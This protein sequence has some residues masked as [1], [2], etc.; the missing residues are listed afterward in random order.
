[1]ETTRRRV[2]WIEFRWKPPGGQRDAPC[3]TVSSNPPEGAMQV[4]RRCSPFGGGQAERQV[5]HQRQDARALCRAG[6]QKVPDGNQ[7]SN[8]LQLKDVPLLYHT[9]RV[10][11]MPV[12]ASQGRPDLCEGRRIEPECNGIARYALRLRLCL[13]LLGTQSWRWRNA[14]LR[15]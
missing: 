10:S 12:G 4:G 5:V 11:D 14:G 9:R 8:T 7:Q 6:P 15:G 2:R 3:K 13:Q 1:M